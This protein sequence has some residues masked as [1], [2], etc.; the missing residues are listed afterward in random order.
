MRPSSIATAPWRIG[1]EETGR[2]QSA[3]RTVLTD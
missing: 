2:T 1:G 3:E